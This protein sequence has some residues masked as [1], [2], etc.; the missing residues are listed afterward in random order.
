MVDRLGVVCDCGLGFCG[1]VIGP[2]V[3]VARIF[4]CDGYDVFAVASGSC[5]IQLVLR[6]I[7]D[8]VSNEHIGAIACQQFAF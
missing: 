6:I 5:S 1:A 4:I 3:A 2:V 7:H 8:L